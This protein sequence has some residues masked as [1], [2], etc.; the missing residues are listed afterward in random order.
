MASGDSQR[1]W[2]TEMLL[3]L[4]EFWNPDRSWEEV[5]IFIDKMQLMRNTI[6][7]DRNVKPVRMFCKNCG[8]YHFS[9]PLKITMRSL[10]FA[11]KKISIASD[12][13]FKDLD[14]NWKKYRKENNLDLYGKKVES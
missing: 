4:K 9:E 3:E 7:K 2:F 5:S 13:E 10:L 6:R 8:E 12:Q 14:K 1:A 11:L